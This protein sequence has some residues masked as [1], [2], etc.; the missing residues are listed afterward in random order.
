MF[1]YWFSVTNF[2]FNPSIKLA[3]RQ[4]LKFFLFFQLSQKFRRT[5]AAADDRQRASSASVVLHRDHQKAKTFG[6]EKMQRH[7][8]SEVMPAKPGQ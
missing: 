6:V 2:T 7:H 5:T 3:K 4:K 1:R 8:D